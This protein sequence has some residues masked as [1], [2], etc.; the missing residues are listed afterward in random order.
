MEIIA[1]YSAN[2]MKY[3]KTLCGKNAE[4]THVKADGYTL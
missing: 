3:I 2:Y 4:I 1:L